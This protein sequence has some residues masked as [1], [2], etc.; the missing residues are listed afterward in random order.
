MPWTP[1][2]S[3]R[4]T[5]MADSPNRKRMWAH[6]A[7]KELA[8]YGDDGR[9]VRAANAAVHKNYRGKSNHRAGMTRT[10]EDT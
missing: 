6:V 8:S 4:H 10:S 2:D 7:N 3:T 9:A 5:K 1:A